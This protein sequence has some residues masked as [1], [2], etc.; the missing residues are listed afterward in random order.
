MDKFQYWNTLRTKSLIKNP[1][2]KSPLVRKGKPIR[3]F[4]DKRAK[5]LRVYEKVKAEFLKRVT[6]CEWEGCNETNIDVHHSRGRCGKYLTDID[7]FRGLCRFHHSHVEV[8]VVEAMS[9]GFTA[10]RLSI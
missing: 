4:S 2:K 3:K 5:E 7:T 9:L 8:H 1:L 10:S 6:V